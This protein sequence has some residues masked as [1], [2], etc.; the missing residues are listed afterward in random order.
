MISFFTSKVG[1]GGY[2]LFAT[3]DQIRV[4]G[5]STAL[6]MDGTFKTCPRPFAQARLDGT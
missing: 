1:A 4:M 6:H 2:I 5:E 3:D